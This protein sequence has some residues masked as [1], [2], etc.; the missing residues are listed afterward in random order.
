[1]DWTFSALIAAY[2]ACKEMGAGKKSRQAVIY[3]LKQPKHVTKAIQDS[4]F[5]K[6]DGRRISMF[7]SPFIHPRIF[8][9]QSCLTI[10]SHNFDFSNLLKLKITKKFEG[11]IKRKL[12]G[13][14]INSYSMS[15]D[16]NGLGEYIKWNHKWNE[17][18]Y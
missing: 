8:A 2:F 10:Q 14:G 18:R 9:Q 13:L 16:L 12:N 4:P 7:E 17:F 6:M 1:L 11:E 3:A 15:P 5:N